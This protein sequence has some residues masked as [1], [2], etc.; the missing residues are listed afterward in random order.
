MF[1]VEKLNAPSLVG[2][3]E[4]KVGSIDHNL[5]TKNDT[6]YE[7][8]Y[9]SGLRVLDARQVRDGKLS[10][11]GFFDVYPADDDA[12]FNGAW[13]N[14]PYFPSGTVVVSGI[15]QGLFV[16]RPT[17]GRGWQGRHVRH[18]RLGLDDRGGRLD[19]VGFAA[20]TK[21]APT[22]GF[23]TV[24]VQRYG[25]RGLELEF[26]RAVS[27]KAAVDVFQQSVG[28]RSSASGSSRASATEVD[29][30]RWNGKANRQGRKVTDGYYFVRYRVPTPKGIDTRRDR[31]A[32]RERQVE[33]PAG[34]LALGALATS[35]G[36]SRSS[37][38]CSAAGRTGALQ[39]AFQARR[40][41]AGP[42]DRVP[43]LEGRQALR[44]AGR[45]ARG[46]RSRLRLG[47][48]KSLRARDLPRADRAPRRHAD[49]DVDPRCE[50]ALAP[51]G[52]SGYGRP[53]S[54]GSRI[55]DE[56][57]RAEIRRAFQALRPQ[58][59]PN[60]HADADLDPHSRI[61][62]FSD[63]DLEQFLNA[64]EAMFMEALDG[65]GRQ[66][67]EFIFETALPP[68]LELGQTALDM[69]R[70]NV[71]SAVML[72][73]RLLPLISEQYRDEAARWLALYHSTYAYE[74][75]ERALALEAE[76]R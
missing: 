11:V 17:R 73:H 62:D 45:A 43:R 16:L 65:S 8:N 7:A 1:N 46:A 67:R 75:A 68:V 35:C 49:R 72:T 33:P 20:A 60:A 71:I 70:S 23:R 2:K 40:C 42:G 30:V 24:G 76:Q 64:Y 9:R 6:V 36:C 28:R 50:T 57:L 26:K 15:E 51:D 53:M 48:S 14:Y 41:R 37:G 63:A 12:E 5:Y 39:I 21:C 3:Y 59:I 44:G 18:G 31:A 58:M 4:A 54:P 34:L 52:R 56:Q 61:G 55:T 29:D 13:S 22:A 10:E 19:R 69:I 38:R 27:S 66:T 25:R 47:A 32:A 74:L